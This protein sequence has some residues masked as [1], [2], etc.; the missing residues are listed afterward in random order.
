MASVTE[1]TRAGLQ[2]NVLYS[3]LTEEPEGLY[4]VVDG[5]VQAKPEMG[6]YEA[7]LAFVLAKLLDNFAQSNQLGQAFVEMLYLLD[8][9]TNLH[10]GPTWPLSPPNAGP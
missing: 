8:R 4:E 9:E 3:Q 1:T 10:A 2:E 7:G 6:A 5:Q